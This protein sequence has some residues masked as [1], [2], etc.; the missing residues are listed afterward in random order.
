MGRNHHRSLPTAPETGGVRM[1]LQAISHAARTVNRPLWAAP[2]IGHAHFWERAVS[3]RGLFLGAGAAAGA[4]AG[5]RLLPPGF[6][7]PARAAASGVEPRPIPG[8]IV[9][10]DQRRFHV[11]PPGRS[12][13]LD[14][15]STINEPSTITDFDGVVAITQT[16]GKGIGI[17]RDT[18]MALS[19]DSDMRFM[20]GRYVGR[21]GNLYEG[22]FGFI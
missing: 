21:D 7:T 17:E 16:Q 19:F 14:A 9:A 10:F 6:G 15:S 3:R 11:Y 4:L 22:A 5:A 2:G 8:G 18:E 1:G 20:A 12:N 13:P